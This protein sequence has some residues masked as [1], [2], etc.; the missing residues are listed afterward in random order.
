[1]SHERPRITVRKLDENHCEFMLEN[2]TP[3]IANTLRRVLQADVPVLAIDEVVIIENDSVLFD[4]ILAHRLAM[5]PLKVDDYT[6]ETLLQCYEEGKREDCIATFILEIEAEKPLTVYSGH[7][8]FSGFSGEMSSLVSAEVK[9]ASDLIPIVKLAPGQKIILEAYAKMGTGKE[10]AKW[11]AATVAYKYYPR[12]LIL[13][14]ECGGNCQKCVEACPR[15]ILSIENDRIKVVENR[16]EECTMCRACEEAC[17]KVIKVSWD[18]GRFIYRVEGVGSLPVSKIIDVSM[19][20]ITWRIDNF[21]N[22]VQKLFFESV[23]AT[24]N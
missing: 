1:M 18:D 23:D 16:I 14:G 6:Y 15:G 13:E 19:R 21:V 9:P 12:L 22:E 4:E 20:R 17:P 24:T 3:A 11:Q 2:V 7:M 10:H 8:K 5:I